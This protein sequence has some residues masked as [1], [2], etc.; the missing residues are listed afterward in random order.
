VTLKTLADSQAFQDIISMIAL[1]GGTQ[2]CWNT[3][4]E[5]MG[6]CCSGV[7]LFR[8]LGST[9]I[10]AGLLAETPSRNQVLCLLC[11]QRGVGGVVTVAGHCNLQP[12]LIDSRR[13]SDFLSPHLKLGEERRSVL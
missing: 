4:Q 3:F 13:A 6:C 11:A 5:N 2:G 1:Q 12:V 9:Q 7:L 8:V 10:V